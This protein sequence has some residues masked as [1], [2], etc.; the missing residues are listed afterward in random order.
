[1][2]FHFTTATPRLS[3]IP[4]TPLIPI[5]QRDAI[6]G[7]WADLL[8]LQDVFVEHSTLDEIKS[9]HDEVVSTYFFVKI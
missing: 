8:I 6:C 2:S 3:I 9:F 5:T 7:F 1:M 4:I